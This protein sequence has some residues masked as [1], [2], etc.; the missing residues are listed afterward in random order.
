MGSFFVVFFFRTL[1]KTIFIYTQVLTPNNDEQF[2][3]RKAK[4]RVDRIKKRKDFNCG[5]FLLHIPLC[6]TGHKMDLCKL[7]VVFI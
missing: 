5:K 7:H 1:S 4:Y 6:L 3:E 2:K